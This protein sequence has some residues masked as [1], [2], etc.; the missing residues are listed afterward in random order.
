MMHCKTQYVEHSHTR[1]TWNAVWAGIPYFLHTGRSYWELHCRNWSWCPHTPSL[2]FLPP[3]VSPGDVQVPLEAC[4]LTSI[5]FLLVLSRVF[6]Y[7][8][9]LGASGPTSR[10][11]EKFTAREALLWNMYSLFFPSSYPRKRSSLRNPPEYV[12]YKTAQ[13]PSSTRGFRI[14]KEYVGLSVYHKLTRVM[15]L[16][17]RMR[18]S[19]FAILCHLTLTLVCE[20]RFS[21]NP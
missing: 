1:D 12:L 13:P 5:F 14:R 11:L 18:L 19:N 4:T 17:M 20:A 3:I 6:L 8:V 15:A 21:C 2:L 9:I 16:F 7:R 10:P